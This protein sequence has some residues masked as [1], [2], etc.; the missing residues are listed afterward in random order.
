MQLL[1]NHNTNNRELR[2]LWL[3]RQRWPNIKENRWA[4]RFTAVNFQT[5]RIKKYIFYML[6]I[7]NKNK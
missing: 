4:P 5:S 2:N 7:K 3:K 6:K 1:K